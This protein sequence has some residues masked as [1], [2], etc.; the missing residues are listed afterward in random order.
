MSAVLSGEV[1]GQ[2]V[3][4]VPWHHNES[5]ALPV[6]FVDDT[7]AVEECHG[8]GQHMFLKPESSLYSCT[9]SVC[10]G[11]TDNLYVYKAGRG[12]RIA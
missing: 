12:K 7:A 2:A 11:Q 3:V 1:G 10:N 8:A 6:S 4:V 9:L 5:E